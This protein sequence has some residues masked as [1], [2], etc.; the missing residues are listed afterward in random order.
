MLEL[1]KYFEKYTEICCKI[2][3]LIA[4]IGI[5]YNPNL[6][7]LIFPFGFGFLILYVSRADSETFYY[8]LGTSDFL[9]TTYIT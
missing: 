7:G 8:F 9:L 3:P 4:I 2:F 1:K 5:I 6:I